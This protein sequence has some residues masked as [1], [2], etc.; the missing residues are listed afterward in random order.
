[1]IRMMYIG[2]GKIMMAIPEQTCQPPAT[3]ELAQPNA[4]NQSA[5]R[6]VCGFIKA[7]NSYSNYFIFYIGRCV[8]IYAR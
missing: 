1:M 5:R 8:L 3:F 4:V 2:Q 6:T 7:V